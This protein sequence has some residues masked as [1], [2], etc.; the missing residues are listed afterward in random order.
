MALCCCGR[1][2]AFLRAMRSRPRRVSY[3]GS[4]CWEYPH[5]QDDEC[6][7]EPSEADPSCREVECGQQDEDEA[8]DEE[9]CG[10]HGVPFGLRYVGLGHPTGLSTA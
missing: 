1:L 8:G 10:E 4:D 7:A 2:D 3:V 6:E 9:D 5:S